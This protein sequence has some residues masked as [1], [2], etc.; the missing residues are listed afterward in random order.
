VSDRRRVPVLKDRQRHPPLKLL[1]ISGY[2]EDKI[3][4]QL[5]TQEGM[6]TLPRRF[7]RNDLL[8]HLDRLLRR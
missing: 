3:F 5:P 8:A 2:P 4:G 6:E 1:F 7:G